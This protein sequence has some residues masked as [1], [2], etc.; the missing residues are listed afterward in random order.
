MKEAQAD[1][2]EGE[3]TKEI[4]G[5]E[6]V[7]Y[8]DY[9][10]WVCDEENGCDPTVMWATLDDGSEIRYRWYKFKDQPTMI[11]AEERVPGH[12]YNR[13]CQCVAGKDRVYT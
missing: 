12:L 5:M 13:I 6:N 11:H 10:C 1:D 4:F 8:L 9:S 7:N 2:V 3:Y